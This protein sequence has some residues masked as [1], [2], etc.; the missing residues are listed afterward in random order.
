MDELV[1]R[2]YD[3]RYLRARRDLLRLPLSEEE[4]C[5]LRALEQAWQSDPS[6]SRPDDDPAGLPASLCRRF[7][8]VSA[9]IPASLEL[10]RTPRPV[11]VVKLGGG[12]MV[13]ETTAPFML[14]HGELAL[15]RIRSTTLGREFQF[16]AQM[17]WQSE[18][19]RGSAHRTALA[20]VGTP[21]ELR[22]GPGRS[23]L[24][25]EAA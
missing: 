4:R 23:A 2:L 22:F 5:R 10:A 1:K 3:Y 6:S 11:V 15:V 19:L 17:R 8:R 13:V 12:G 7:A 21:L 18:R 9:S 14:R 25:A 24:A 20:L 16:H